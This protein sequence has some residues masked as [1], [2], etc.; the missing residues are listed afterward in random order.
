MKVPGGKDARLL[1]RMGS[2][3]WS[4]PLDLRGIGAVSRLPV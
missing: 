3:G 4:K 2:L 1:S